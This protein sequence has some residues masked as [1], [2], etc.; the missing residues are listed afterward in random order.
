MKPRITARLVA[1]DSIPL[2]A[3]SWLASP[4]TDGRLPAA[5]IQCSF[6]ES[7]A[8]MKRS[9]ANMAAS[10]S[11]APLTP[12]KIVNPTTSIGEP[13]AAAQAKSVL[14]RAV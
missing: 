10:S 8:R 11:R 3:R 9:A 2:R 7:V 1:H 13:A 12:G 5:Q 4:C 14:S 6:D